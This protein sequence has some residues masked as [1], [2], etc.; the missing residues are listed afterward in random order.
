MAAWNL[1]KF[2]LRILTA[3]LIVVSLQA[4]TSVSNAA[5]EPCVSVSAT[6]HEADDAHH[7]R[8]CCGDMHC[9]PLVPNVFEP[10]VTTVC[11]YKIG[12]MPRLTFRPL[13]I[14]R[15]LYPPPK[16]LLRRF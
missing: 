16:H 1:P 10:S 9:C 11:L 6:S 2:L 3:A 12:S 15:S 14:V 5:D 7:A 8:V 4:M 13:M